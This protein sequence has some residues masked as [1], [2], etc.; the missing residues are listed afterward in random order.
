MNNA[1]RHSRSARCHALKLMDVLSVEKFQVFR[2]AFAVPSGLQ[3]VLNALTFREAGQPSALNR[4]YMNKGV[5]RSVFRFDKAK[6]PGCVEKFHCS[7]CHLH[8]PYQSIV[9]AQRCPGRSQVIKSG[10]IVARSACRS[11]H[12]PSIRVLADPPRMVRY[13]V[14]N[15]N[16]IRSEPVDV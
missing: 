2:R 11:A 10:N 14:R 9:G 4:G 7:D 1:A 6:S 5:F 8:S 15:G 16:R 3:F 13:G 12:T